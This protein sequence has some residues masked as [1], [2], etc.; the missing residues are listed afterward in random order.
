MQ[1][2]V[3][4]GEL[5]VAA[6][7]VLEHIHTFTALARESKR[8]KVVMVLPE[9]ETKPIHMKMALEK[10]HFNKCKILCLMQ[11]KVSFSF[12]FSLSVRETSEREKTDP[13][14]S[15]QTFIHKRE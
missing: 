15:Q 9:S 5:E 14:L 3:F 6:V 8:E 1:G 11:L 2:S 13:D 10:S 7:R 4:D 12:A